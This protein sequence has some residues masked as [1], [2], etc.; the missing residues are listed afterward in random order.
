MKEKQA[1]VLCAII[2]LVFII[3]FASCSEE[4]SRREGAYYVSAD[5]NLASD[6][7]SG[8]KAQPWTLNALQSHTLLPGD[9]VY[10]M[11][12]FYE[13]ALEIKSS[14]TK[15]SPIVFRSAG[16][17]GKTIFSN[18][19][20]SKQNGNVFFITGKHITLDGLLFK[21]CANA[22]TKEDKKILQ[23]GAVYAQTGADYLT[24]KN[25]EFIDCPIGINVNAQHA[26]LTSNKIRDCNRFLSEPDWGPLGILIGNA[27]NEISYNTCWNYVKVGGNYGADGGFIELDDRY[28][29]NKVHD[30]KIHHNLS[31]EN[32]GFV[33]IEGKVTGGNLDVY[34][35]V[36]D[37]YQQFIFY[38]GGDSSKIENNTVIRTRP[39]NHGSVNTVF[40][41]K[42]ENFIIRNNIF[43]VANG[44]Q[45]LKTAPYD[46]TYGNVVHE[47]NIYFSADASADNPCG[48][49]LGPGELIADPGFLDMARSNYHLLPT[50]AAVGGGQPL[51]YTHDFDRVKI[52]AGQ[53][54]EIGAL[55]KT[56]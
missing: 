1:K 29:G 41:M 45:V 44:I 37:D 15:E 42:N 49:A 33:E 51:G 34:Y 3:A 8:S 21:E 46:H 11:E 39:P 35:N 53:P 32:Q 24:V 20:F 26:L 19:S 38:W 52:P 18:P 12:G 36:S 7:N 13:A 25:C 17:P 4:N 30:V 9:T 27:Y 23:V 28:F 48:K 14:G 54:P 55:Q 6:S 56:E 50:S 10:F 22:A 40:T 16:S 5:G 47:N 2:G 31:Y 43:V